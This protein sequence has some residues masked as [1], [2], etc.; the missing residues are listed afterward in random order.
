[1]ERVNSEIIRN[2]EDVLIMLDSI[3]EKR[4]SEW[5]NNFYS[6][7]GKA[8]PFFKNV[9]DENL[10][11]YFDLE[12]LKGGKALDIGCGNGRNSFY[13]AHKGFQVYGIDFSETSTKWGKQLAKE[14]S[15]ELNFICQSIFDF[16]C[17]PES[18]DFIYDSGCFHHIKPHRRSSYLNTIL[19][20]LKPDGYFAMTCFNLDG[21]ANISDYDVYRDH[22]MHGGL[23]FSEYKL[24]S[25]LD[26][27]FEI[28]EFREM[29][30]S[31]DENIFGKSF[32]WT[33]L[34]KKK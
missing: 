22:S 30:E 16:Q 33:V 32:L 13:L 29:K 15:I 24:R 28:I 23:G 14:K 9:P 7:K 26:S 31:N 20:F 12:I 25:I 17:E 18:C 34:M 19:K 1:V 3:L 4:D 10:I 27:Y 6:N 2:G 5:W 11:T 21:G 8:I